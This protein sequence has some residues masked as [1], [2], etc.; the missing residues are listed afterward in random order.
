MFSLAKGNLSKCGN[1]YLTEGLV[2]LLQG[3]ILLYVNL[4]ILI[5]NRIRSLVICNLIF[6]SQVSYSTL[7]RYISGQILKRKSNPHKIA[8]LLP[9]WP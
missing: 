4:D 6:I 3:Y 8:N 2:S 9:E 5:V 1:N 7:P